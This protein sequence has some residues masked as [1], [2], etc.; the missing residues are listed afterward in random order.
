[1]RTLRNETN[2]FLVFLFQFNR[3]TICQMI[4]SNRIQGHCLLLWCDFEPHNKTRNSQNWIKFVAWNKNLPEQHR[5]SRK[6]LIN[7]VYTRL[8]THD[9]GRKHWMQTQNYNR[10]IHKCFRHL[11]NS[12]TKYS[13]A[14]FF[15]LSLEFFF[16]INCSYQFSA[17]HNRWTK[18]QRIECCQCRAFIHNWIGMSFV[19]IFFSLSLFFC[20]RSWSCFGFCF[21]SQN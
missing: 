6:Y 20:S 5:N 16:S 7:V 12:W 14:S 21:E 1:M 10:N 19:Y 2:L 3:F 17:I 9:A 18:C 8:I 11:T 4:A 15:L 13:S